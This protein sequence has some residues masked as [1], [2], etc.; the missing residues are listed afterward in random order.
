MLRKSYVDLFAAPSGRGEKGAPVA[1][2]R[3]LFFG[4]NWLGCLE[5]EVLR[6]TI[7]IHLWRH[8]AGKIQTDLVPEK[9]LG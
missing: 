4:D 5:L 2:A 1:L 8:Q 7:S 9:L 6:A 3:F